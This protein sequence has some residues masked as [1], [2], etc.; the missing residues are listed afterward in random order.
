VNT[1]QAPSNPFQPIPTPH[2]TQ[3]AYNPEQ[4]AKANIFGPPPTTFPGMPPLPNA[5]APRFPPATTP[6]SSTPPTTFNSTPTP[7][8]PLS[9][10]QPS[11]FLG[12]Q[13]APPSQ[14]QNS[15][16]NQQQATPPPP[17]PGGFYAQQQAAFQSGPPVANF[18]PNNA[19]PPQAPATIN[20]SFVQQPPPPMAPQQSYGAYPQQHSYFNPVQQY[21]K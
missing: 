7:P 5:A 14:Q 9:N 12:Q 8:P 17:Q 15:F 4:Q 1:H 18:N 21:P 11:N 19:F 10:A 3:A 6:N 20:P 16:Y 13:A 2:F